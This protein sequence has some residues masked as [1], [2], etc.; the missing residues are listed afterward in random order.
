MGLQ[1]SNSLHTGGPHEIPVGVYVVVQ[2]TTELVGAVGICPG[3]D[4]EIDFAEDIRTV[5]VQSPDNGQSGFT[6][7]R[8]VAVDVGAHKN[9]SLA[10]VH[11][12]RCGV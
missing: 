5:L 11:S 6:R 2:E 1:K 3:N 4:T 9:G 10:L 8:L 7:G 12:F